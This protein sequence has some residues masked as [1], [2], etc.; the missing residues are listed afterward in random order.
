MTAGSTSD[1]VDCDNDAM[2]L[3]S[4]VPLLVIAVAVVILA[5]RSF[6]R[7]LR[8]PANAFWLMATL[9]VGAI[10]LSALTGGRNPLNLVM[11][12]AFMLLPLETLALVGALLLNGVV[13]IR[14]EGRSLANLLSL[15][16]GLA[17]IGIMA[18][19]IAA[20]IAIQ[21]T[22]WLLVAAVTLAALAGW[23]GF[24]FT[25]YLLYSLLYPRLWRRPA[26]DFVVVHGS[27]L[28]GGKVA[29][30]LGS[31]IDTGIARWT[32][33]GG[34][35]PLILSG[36]Q[37][38]DEP[39]SEASAMAEYARERGVPEDAIV[40]E[41]RSRTTEENLAF[42]RD[43]VHE[44]IGPQAKGVAVTSDYHVL[45]TAALARDVGIDVHVAPAHSA[46]YFRVNAFMREV[47]ALVNRN[48]VRHLVAFAIAFLPVLLLLT[49]IVL[50]RPA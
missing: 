43:M 32:A 6:R 3:V 39:R 36:G 49:I 27:G 4:Y 45:R 12:T 41:D 23:A 28:V 13:T 47:V 7:D 5:V 44:M 38:P 20:I 9:V 35:I 33:A 11:T 18:L 24:L 22:P 16:A 42:T 46:L 15:L 14:R 31:R 40:L 37:G 21:L 1:C 19:G 48:R 25:S 30:L 26:P 10:V 8:S 34:G 17:I 2:P 29:R 50:E